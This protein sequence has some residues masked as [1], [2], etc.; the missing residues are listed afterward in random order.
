M[1]L[2][3]N[4]M[5][6]YGAN[7]FP[8][9]VLSAVG[10]DRHLSGSP[11]RPTEEIG[12][13]AADLAKSPGLLGGRRR[14]S[15]VVRVGSSRGTR[16]VDSDP[17]RKL[18]ASRDNRVFVVNDQVWQTGARVWSLPAALSVICAGSTPI[19]LV[20]HSARLWDTHS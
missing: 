13:T 6:V 10:V 20:R 14:S 4:T 15:P 19:Q 12:T 5:R 9:S 1:Q 18:S 17:W 7:N 2:T 8:A 11:T 16:G 3:A